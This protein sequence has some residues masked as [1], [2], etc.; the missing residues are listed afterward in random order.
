MDACDPST[1]ASGSR[2]MPQGAV[3]VCL[4]AGCMVCVC[5]MQHVPTPCGSRARGRLWDG[6]MAEGVAVTCGGGA[7]SGPELSVGG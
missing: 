4:L 2:A 5:S 7:Q 1:V 6:D 3:R